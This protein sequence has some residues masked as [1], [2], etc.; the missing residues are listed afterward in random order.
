MHK[1]TH[2]LTGRPRPDLSPAG[3]LKRFPVVHVKEIDCVTL[4]AGNKNVKVNSPYSVGEFEL[5]LLLGVCM[6]GRDAGLA[7]GR[8]GRGGT[9]ARRE[10]SSTPTGFRRSGSVVR[11]N[12]QS[13]P[14]VTVAAL[15]LLAGL[16]FLDA[17]EDVARRWRRHPVQVLFE[18]T[19]AALATARLEG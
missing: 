1:G 17:P 11:G 18:V 2:T 10:T 6:D 12:G 14:G 16:D 5:G 3:R 7:G 15:F 9:G 19:S 4:K 8:R 13:R